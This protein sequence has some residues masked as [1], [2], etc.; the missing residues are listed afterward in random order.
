M[1]K[2]VLPKVEGEALG[3]VESLDLDKTYRSAAPECV[4]TQRKHAEP[5]FPKVAYAQGWLSW[6]VIREGMQKSVFP[7]VEGEAL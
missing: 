2:S 6:W 5:H 3:G 4:R 1:Q 7:K